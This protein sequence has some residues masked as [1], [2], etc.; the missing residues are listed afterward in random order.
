[1]SRFRYLCW[2]KLLE[3]SER[4]FVDFFRAPPQTNHQ[5]KILSGADNHDNSDDLYL[6]AMDNL[7]EFHAYT[8]IERTDIL[9]TQLLSEYSL[10]N[11]ISR[12][13]NVSPTWTAKIGFDKYKDEILSLNSQDTALYKYVNQNE[14]LKYY[15]D[16]ANTSVNAL[17]T[18]ITSSRNRGW[19]PH[20]IETARLLEALNNDYENTYAML[21]EYLGDKFAD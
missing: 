1:M 6:R 14:K 10:T 17:T 9:L 5:S 16:N 2:L 4:S 8:T 20:C 7:Q 13:L 12:R 11:V 15:S 18:V 3:Y 19:I 21:K